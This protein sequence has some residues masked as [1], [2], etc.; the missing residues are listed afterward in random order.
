MTQQ[1]LQ[2]YMKFFLHKIPHI[3]MKKSYFKTKYFRL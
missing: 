2:M 1:T 3:R